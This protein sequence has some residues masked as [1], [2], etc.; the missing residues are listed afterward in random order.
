MDVVENGQKTKVKDMFGFKMISEN[1][2]TT[3]QIDRNVWTREM[4]DLLREY[5]RTAP[6]GA[7]YR[8]I[9]WTKEYE[10]AMNSADDQQSS[11]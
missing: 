10:L 3:A 6:E 5:I 4:L 9:D 1:K 8:D 11:L 2:F 7:E